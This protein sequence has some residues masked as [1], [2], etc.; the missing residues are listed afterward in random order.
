MQFSSLDWKEETK[1][2]SGML[3]YKGEKPK[4]KGLQVVSEE[5]QEQADREALTAK[6]QGID[7]KLGQQSGGGKASSHETSEGC[8]PLEGL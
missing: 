5:Q 4:E 1:G 3:A 8:Q 2:A 7:R 6:R